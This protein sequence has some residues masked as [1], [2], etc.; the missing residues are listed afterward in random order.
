MGLQIEK[1]IIQK[2]IENV[3]GKAVCWESKV[4]LECMRK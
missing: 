4:T 3:E 1:R 2:R